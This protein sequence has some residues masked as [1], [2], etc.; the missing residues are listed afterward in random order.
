[1][2]AEDVPPATSSRTRVSLLHGFWIANESRAT[3]QLEAHAT[4][5]RR[6]RRNICSIFSEI[7][8]QLP[9]IVPRVKRVEK[10]R[11]EQR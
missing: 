8:K 4:K 3:R 7:V 11:H 6:L 5:K 2:L 9:P 1:M 10:R